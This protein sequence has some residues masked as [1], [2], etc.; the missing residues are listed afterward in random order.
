MF[1]LLRAGKYV[2]FPPLMWSVSV[3]IRDFLEIFFS[4][5]LLSS[6]LYP[7]MGKISRKSTFL[8]WYHL[9][10]RKRLSEP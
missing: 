4:F 7:E 2:F 9:I 10:T 1:I 6:F 3:L 5:R 8:K